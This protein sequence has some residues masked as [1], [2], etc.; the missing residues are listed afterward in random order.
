[1]ADKNEK[2]ENVIKQKISDFSDLLESIEN[3]DLKQK[4][5]YIEIY[6]NAVKDRT[7][8]ETLLLTLMSLAGQTSTEHAVHGRT[9]AAYIE[10]MTRSNDQLIKLAEVITNLNPNDDK[11]DPDK[12]FA[13]INSKK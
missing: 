9:M 13:Q 5:L 2:L 8:A 4:R 3:L 11:F 10:R 1:M 6:E 12:L 7:S